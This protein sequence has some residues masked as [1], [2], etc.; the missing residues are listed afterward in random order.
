MRCQTVTMRQHL[1]ER[2][3][4]DACNIEGVDPDEIFVVDSLGDR[5]FDNGLRIINPE[6]NTTPD[7]I[8][9][10]MECLNNILQIFD[11]YDP[12]AY[13]GFQQPDHLSKI[14]KA[15]AALADQR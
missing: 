11:S 5:Y 1:H 2:K 7:Q 12:E 9:A 14:A 13:H 3:W 4:I 8:K 6:F 10:G 15:K